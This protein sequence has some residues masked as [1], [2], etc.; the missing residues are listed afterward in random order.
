MKDGQDIKN[1]LQDK[2]L[3]VISERTGVPYH[4]L[5]HIKRGQTKQVTD[6]TAD[7]LE[8]LMP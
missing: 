8:A 4:T 7:A 5:W 6:D 1:W 3:T 2:D